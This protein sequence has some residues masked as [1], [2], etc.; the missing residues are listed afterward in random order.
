MESRESKESRE[1]RE[2]KET[3]ISF[4]MWRRQRH[5]LSLSPNWT[6][7]TILKA[8]ASLTLYRLHVWCSQPCRGATTG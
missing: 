3:M 4:R 7:K 2:S 8:V 5:R 1:S 6:K